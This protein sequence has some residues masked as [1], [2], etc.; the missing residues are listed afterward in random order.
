MSAAV[1]RDS[2]DSPAPFSTASLPSASLLSASHVEITSR[3]PDSVPGAPSTSA[4]RV[5][6]S[7]RDMTLLLCLLTLVIMSL[8]GSEAN[9]RI[10]L[11]PSLAIAL[12]QL[13]PNTPPDSRHKDVNRP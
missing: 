1:I 13:P 7:C 10:G 4:D 6:M 2:R 12:F 8:S 11:S 3:P 5:Y 9:D